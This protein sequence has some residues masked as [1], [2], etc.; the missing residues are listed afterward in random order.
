MREQY[1]TV[2]HYARIEIEERKS[3]FIATCS[4]LASEAEAIN[5]LSGIRD[6]FPDAT[7]HVYAWIIG[8]EQTLQRYS[9]DGEP[10]GTAGL[11]V[12]DVLRKGGIVSAGLVVTR[13]FG[14]TL[15]GSG[16]LVRAYSQAA[17]LALQAAE[18]VTLLLCQRFDLTVSYSDLDILRC[19]LE[20]AGFHLEAPRFGIDAELVVGTPAAR[21]AELIALCQDLTAGSALIEPAEPA[22]IPLPPPDPPA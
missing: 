9:D 6:E 20:Q 16:G 5:L 15:L 4:P 19:R 22:Y 11:P 8:G 12:L 3:R 1:R 10:Q 17:T 2:R 14:G 13:Y 18:P 21:V 7:H